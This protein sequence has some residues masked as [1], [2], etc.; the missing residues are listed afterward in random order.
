METNQL[1][2]KLARALHQN[3]CAVAHE[4]GDDNTDCVYPTAFAMQDA[5]TLLPILD[6]SHADAFDAGWIARAERE[7]IYQS[8]V[9]SAPPPHRRFNPYRRP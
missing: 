4:Y 3:H 2:E 5:R 6:E 9:T 7:N 8:R 1:I